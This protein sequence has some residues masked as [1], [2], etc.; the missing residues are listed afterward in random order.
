MKTATDGMTHFREMEQ[1]QFCPLA[2]QSTNITSINTYIIYSS[3]IAVS[4][5]PLNMTD[6]SGYLKC[7]RIIY[8]RKQTKFRLR[9]FL[10]QKHS[11]E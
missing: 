8:A 9:V 1:L 7:K 4:S 3:I 5:D 2:T 11:F 10:F 6:F